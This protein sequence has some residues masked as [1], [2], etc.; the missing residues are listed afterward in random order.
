[1]GLLQCR[2][3]DLFHYFRGLLTVQRRPATYVISRRD[4]QINPSSSERACNHS[5]L[6]SRVAC[7]ESVLHLGAHL[8]HT[9]L[10]GHAKSNIKKL[11]FSGIC[12]GF[13]DYINI[14]HCRLYFIFLLLLFTQMQS[15]S[16]DFFV[17]CVR[18]SHHL[19]IVTHSEWVL[20]SYLTGQQ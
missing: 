10:Y 19:V 6:L 1:M 11:W 7:M 20:F 5:G 17:I 12:S 9:F 2:A 16:D 15:N 13:K 14:H 8:R 18:K 3:L 4:N